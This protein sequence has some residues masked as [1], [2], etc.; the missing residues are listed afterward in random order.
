MFEYYAIKMSMSIPLICF[1]N[2]DNTIRH[3]N[4]SNLLLL[5]NLWEMDVTKKEK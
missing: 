1:V 4:A 2:I 5:I 3:I